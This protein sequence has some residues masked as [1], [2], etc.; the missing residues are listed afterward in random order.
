MCNHL[1]TQYWHVMKNKCLVSS[2]SFI[3]VYGKR[4]GGVLQTY[5]VQA[6]GELIK[7][8]IPL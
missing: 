1:L 7:H 5:L 3:M 8:G 2:K 6:L 4:Q